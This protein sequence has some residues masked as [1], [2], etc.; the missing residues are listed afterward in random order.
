MDQTQEALL[1]TASN[2]NLKYA[3]IIETITKVFPNGKCT[4]WPKPRDV[5]LANYETADEVMMVSAPNDIQEEMFEIITDFIQLHDADDEDSIEM[6]E[7]YVD[8]RKKLQN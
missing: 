3:D 8:I 4:T 2:G 5:F 7:I 1:L 6:F